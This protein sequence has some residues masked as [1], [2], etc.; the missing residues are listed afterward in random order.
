MTDI[1][2][3]P[4]VAAPEGVTADP[5]QLAAAREHWVSLGLAPEA[6]DKALSADPEAADGVQGEPGLD[7]IGATG[8]PTVTQAQA[9]EMA[10]ALAAAGVPEREIIAALAADGHDPAAIDDRTPEQK[11]FDAVFGA[12]PK[13]SDYKPNYMGRAGHMDIGQLAQFD[14]AMRGW[15]ADVGL[16]PELGGAVIERAVD[17]GRAFTRMGDAERQLWIR[18]QQVEFER[19]A[20]GP[21]QAQAKIKLAAAALARSPVAFEGLQKSPAMHDAWI[22]ETLANNEARLRERG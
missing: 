20:G 17:I 21:E 16:L 8:A 2:E 10:Q 13:A 9:L 14:A 15:A 7:I 1:L 5:A 6:F 3:A 12:A 11:E 22:V 18:G 19:R 4:P